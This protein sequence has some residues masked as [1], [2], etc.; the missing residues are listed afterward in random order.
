MLYSPSIARVAVGIM[1]VVV[2]IG[3]I[4]VAGGT[5]VVATVVVVWGGPSN[6]SAFLKAIFSAV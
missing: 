3:I 5:L 2:V 4:A 1:L 6:F